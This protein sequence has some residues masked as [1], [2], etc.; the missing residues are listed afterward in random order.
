MADKYAK[1]CQVCGG[2]YPGDCFRDGCKDPS[3]TCDGCEIHFN[4][5]I[6]RDDECKCSPVEVCDACLLQEVHW[7][8]DD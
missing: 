5:V 3:C 1:P 2:Y 4:G 6:E 7:G 8:E